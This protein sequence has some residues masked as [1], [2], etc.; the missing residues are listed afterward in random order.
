MLGFFKKG[1]AKSDPPATAVESTSWFD[2]LK[3]GLRKTG[4]QL[5]GLFVGRKI[6]EALFE[7]LETALLQ[8]DAGVQATEHL[9][10]ALRQRVKRDRLETADQLKLALEAELTTMLAPSSVRWTV[11][12]ANRS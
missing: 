11:G 7:S 6:D 9:L 12:S 2:R 4:S 1:E 8:A 3:K 10:Q 5:G